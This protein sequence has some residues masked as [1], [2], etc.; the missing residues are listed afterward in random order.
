MRALL[1][2]GCPEVPVQTGIALYIA[3]KLKDEGFEV[4]TAGTPSAINLMRV[5]DPKKAYIDSYIEIE[6]CVDQMGEGKFDVDVS[7]GFIHKDSGLQYLAT[8][9]A[10]SNGAPVAIVFGREAEELSNEV[11]EALDNC[12]V[13]WAKAVHNP[14]ELKKR[15]DEVARWASVLKR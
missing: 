11:K 13:L 12:V 3:N 2:L 9:A 8:V 4:V 5:A 15:I 1:L 10:L 6:R 14:M 7:F